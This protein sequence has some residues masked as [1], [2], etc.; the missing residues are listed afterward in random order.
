M[1]AVLVA[2]PR[3]A[4]AQSTATGDISGQ[5][6]RDDDLRP[7]PGSRIQLVGVYPPRFPSAKGTFR[8]DRLFPS[9][10]KIHVISLGFI[11]YDTIVVVKPRTV[12][13]VTIRM[14][15]VPVELSAV[16]ITEAVKRC[17]EGSA[18]T[19]DGSSCI[20]RKPPAPPKRPMECGPMM[21]VVPRTF[22]CTS[23]R[24]LPR[25]TLEDAASFSGSNWKILEAA[26]NAVANSG[27]VVESVLQMNERTWR[28][29]AH[30]FRRPA[31]VEAL[32]VDVVEVGPDDTDVRVS[33][34][35]SSP[36]GQSDSE[37]PARQIVREIRRALR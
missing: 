16:T 6:L 31:D 34:Y 4:E 14:K 5:V 10:Y 2:M 33:L 20:A 24:M 36:L 35:I 18:P 25:K 15:A 23:N 27:F 37:Q 26:Q 22:L 21:L 11:P 12:T 28:I 7:L 19:T 8:F 3:D 1:I 29:S 13:S 17:P 32:K 30:S 9:A